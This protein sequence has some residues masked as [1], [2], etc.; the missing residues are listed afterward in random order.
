MACAPKE[1]IHN[2]F[3]G[4]EYAIRIHGSQF[5][6]NRG[7]MVNTADKYEFLYAEFWAPPRDRDTRHRYCRFA[8]CTEVPRAMRAS[9]FGKQ[10]QGPYQMQYGNG[11]GKGKGNGK[12]GYGREYQYQMAYVDEPTAPTAPVAPVAPVPPA[13]PV[14]P[15][16]PVAHAHGAPAPAAAAA[17]TASSSW[18]QSGQDGHWGSSCQ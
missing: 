9:A 10:K 15:V 2:N 8:H 4:A 5:K 12:D 16:A 11:K 1:E 13:A 18:Q 7:I 17:G 3:L 14:A 6:L